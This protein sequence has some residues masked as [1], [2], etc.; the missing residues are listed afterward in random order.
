MKIISCEK[1][2]FLPEISLIIINI[3]FLLKIL[4]ELREKDFGERKKKKLFST[5]IQIGWMSKGSWMDGYTLGSFGILNSAVFRSKGRMRC[6]RI[7][8][9]LKL[10]LKMKFIL[11]LTI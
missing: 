8:N 4:G 2:Y 9:R 7:L 5:Q 11:D 10:S 3:I 6:Y 1:L